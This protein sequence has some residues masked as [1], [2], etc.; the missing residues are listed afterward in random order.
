[1]SSFMNDHNSGDKIAED[2]IILFVYSIDLRIDASL[3]SFKNFLKFG[4]IEVK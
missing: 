3:C 1:L 4:P 2:V